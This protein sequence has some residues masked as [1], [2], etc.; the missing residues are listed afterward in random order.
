MYSGVIGRFSV[1][2]VH[3]DPDARAWNDG[4]GETLTQPGDE[5]GGTRKL[6]PPL[7]PRTAI[8][9]RGQAA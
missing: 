8:G 1:S 7:V 2:R 4:P 3:L 9:T 5:H 6:V